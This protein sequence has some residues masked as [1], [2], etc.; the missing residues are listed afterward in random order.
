MLKKIIWTLLALTLLLSACG[1]GTF[2]VTEDSDKT[3]GG[4]VLENIRAGLPA[5]LPPGLAVYEGVNAEQVYVDTGINL[6]KDF[7]YTSSA[8]PSVLVDFYLDSL[9]AAGWELLLK[10]D[11]TSY[12]SL[13]FKRDKTRINI[14]VFAEVPATYPEELE[15]AGTFV[16]V[17][18]DFETPPAP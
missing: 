14:S 7:F 16:T 12:T 1:K 15:L 10:K 9:Q 6:G 11:Q 8:E 4:P 2:D 18:Y 17:I 13:Q 5:G 3:L